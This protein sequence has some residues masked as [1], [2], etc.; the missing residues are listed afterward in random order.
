THGRMQDPTEH[1]FHFYH[2]R[3]YHEGTM[4]RCPED[5]IHRPFYDSTD[6]HHYRDH[7]R[8]VD[9]DGDPP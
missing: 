6:N 1:I 4:P 2:N 3:A 7:S 9:C 8:E 5:H